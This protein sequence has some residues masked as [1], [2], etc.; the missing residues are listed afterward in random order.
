MKQ[1]SI[2][3][4]VSVSNWVGFDLTITHSPWIIHMGYLISGIKFEFKTDRG[5]ITMSGWV[6]IGS[7]ILILGL[8]LFVFK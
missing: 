1:Y 4:Y 6:I 7:L 8:S 2:L 5:V 3:G